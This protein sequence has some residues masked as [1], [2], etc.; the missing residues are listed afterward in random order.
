MKR[1]MLSMHG[2]M[3][4]TCVP[5]FGVLYNLEPISE[6]A[7]SEPKSA[8]THICATLEAES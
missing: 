7:Y 5:V 2:D 1:T 6:R 4:E 3:S 8:Y